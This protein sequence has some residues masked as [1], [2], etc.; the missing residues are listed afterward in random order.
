ML[1]RVD[2][3]IIPVDFVVMESADEGR[4]HIRE[5]VV[6]LGRP[7]MVTT[8]TFLELKGK[9]ISMEVMGEI[10]ELVGCSIGLKNGPTEE[11]NFID[12]LDSVTAY[13]SLI[14]NTGDPLEEVL[15]M[16][17]SEIPLSE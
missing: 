6:L 15:N 9:K 12:C 16:Q 11:L 10:I 1:V 17:E 2:K 8:N 5:H 3:L 13:H 4:S 7:F 14:Y